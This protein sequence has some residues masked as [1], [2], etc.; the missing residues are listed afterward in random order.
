M[1]HGS[2]ISVYSYIR[3]RGRREIRRAHCCSLIDVA[4]AARRTQGAAG[5]EVGRERRRGE[6]TRACVRACRIRRWDAC[7]ARTRATADRWAGKEE[8]EVVEL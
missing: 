5:P 3:R 1:L 4:V 8:E 7:A 2:I 6:G